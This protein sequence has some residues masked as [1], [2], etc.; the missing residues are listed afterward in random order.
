MNG[1]PFAAARAVAD[2]VLY[3]GYVL[4][5]YRASSS[6]NQTRWQFGVL[7]PASYVEVDASERASCQTGI[8][9]E[10]KHDA[11]LRVQLRFLHLRHRTGAG[12]PE[13]DE[14][15]ERQLEFDLGVA[16]LLSGAHEERFSFPGAVETEHGARRETRPVNGCVVVTATELPARL[17][18]CAFAYGSRTRRRRRRPIGTMRCVRLSSPCTPCSR[19]SGAGLFR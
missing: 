17:V 8:L 16:A 12:L 2:A 4:Y 3:E 18:H 19:W 1:D 13:W 10:S 11:M 14:T 15:V 5:P 7:M 9:F 6:K